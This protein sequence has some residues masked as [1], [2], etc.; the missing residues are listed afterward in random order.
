MAVIGG[1]RVT[2][3]LTQDAVSAA[4]CAGRRVVRTARVPI[5]RE[6]WSGAWSEG[7]IAYD[8]ALQSVLRQAGAGSKPVVRILAESPTSFARVETIRSAG[9]TALAAGE[10]RAAGAS[11]DE[12]QSMVTGAAII[13]EDDEAD[14]VVR[15]HVL[16]A[17]DEDGAA[18]ALFAWVARAGGRAESYVPRR[19]AALAAVFDRAIAF[20]NPLQTA[21]CYIDLGSSALIAMHEGRLELVRGIGVGYQAFAEAYARAEAHAATRPEGD[22]NTEDDA[23]LGEPELDMLLGEELLRDNGVPGKGAPISRPDNPR[24]RSAGPLLAPVVQRLCVEVKQ[25]LRY[26]VLEA[27]RRPKRMILLGP[28]A[29]VPGLADAL[30]SSTELDTNVPSGTPTGRLEPFSETTLEGEFARGLCTALRILPR[31]ASQR[32]EASHRAAGIR[33]AVLVAGGLLLAEAGVISLQRGAVDRRFVNAATEIGDVREFREAHD[34]AD[35]IGEALSTAAFTSEQLVGSQPEWRSVILEIAAAAQDRVTLSEIRGF[36]EGNAARVL[37][38]GTA[39]TEGEGQSPFRAFTERLQRSPLVE[40]VEIG[41]TTVIELEGVEMRRF[42]LR[43]VVHTLPVGHM[44]P[45]LIAG[46][47]PDGVEVNP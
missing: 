29:G 26:G 8:R 3:V 17:G 23:D 39:P 47:A 1:K 16:V 46:V 22:N 27:G 36:Y 21:F 40:R 24:R 10:L 2:V 37:I 9:A 25:T 41:S 42:S 43:C 30:F 15:S 20:E 32:I 33:T 38:S 12:D 44:H 45:E 14:G 5:D 19:A 11:G 6:L 31:S 7:L 4:V 18:Q 13:A 35:E 34:R 28:G